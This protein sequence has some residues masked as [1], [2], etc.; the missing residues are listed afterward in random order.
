MVN[1]FN[2]KFFF[3]L[4]FTLI[5]LI[6]FYRSPYIFINGRFFAEEGYV[7]FQN[8]FQNSFF[9]NLFFVEL[10]AGYINF[11]ANILTSFAVKIPLIY[12]PYVTVYGS[13]FIILLPVYFILFRQSVLFD[14]KTKKILGSLI[15]FISTPL[16]P[17]IWLNS[18]NLQVY[19]CLS[20]II[21]IFMID[22]NIYQKII[23]NITI[24]IGAFSGIYT[25]SLLPIFFIKFLREK[26]KYNFNNLVIL[27]IGNI[28]Q[29]SLIINSQIN[30]YLTPT[31][32]KADL[33]IN[34][35]FL[36]IY[37][38]LVRPFTG[39]ELA[40][41]VWNSKLLDYKFFF[42]I[43]LFILLFFL[44]YFMRRNF[45]DLYKI[46]KKDSIFLK[47]IIIFFTICLIISVGSLGSYFGG[48]YAAIPGIV[49]LLMILHLS[50]IVSRK[51][52][53]LL[54]TILFFALFNG[55]NEFR[56]HDKSSEFGL[57]M[58]DCIKCPNWKNE[59]IK[60]QNDKT[61]TIKIW[62]YPRKTMRLEI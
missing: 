3:S 9:K 15:F 48:R 32:L 20:S 41:Y 33:T 46:I 16:V 11:I 38:I 45:I 58:L 34:S 51:L 42:I 4:F 14:H 49:M 17:E 54:M 5:I 56:P 59:I 61:Y 29:I 2:K 13:F 1:F 37:N 23:N 18:I 25:C 60:W 52:K 35:L 12:A 27:I 62:P 31:V 36:F 6:S 39:R 57:K 44:I 26:N 10:H 19:L 50:F 30:S 43:L 24:L 40:L 7:Y 28:V 47:L 21:I 8:A 22:L 55:I 53:F